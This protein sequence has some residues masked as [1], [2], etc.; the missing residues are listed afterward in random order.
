MLNRLPEIIEP[1]HLADKRGS[2]KGQLPINGLKRLCELLYSDEG[3]VTVD[4]FFNRE[5]RLAIV[6]GTIQAELQ[7]KC[8]NCLEALAWSVNHTVNLAIVNSIDQVNRLSE[9]YDPLLLEQG[10]MLL[11]DLVEDE[12]LLSLPIYP[13][14][15]H[16]C[17]VATDNHKTNLSEE[18]SASTNPF[19]I[20][21]TLKNIGD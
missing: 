2:L 3:L 19:S 1:L 7:L 20:L 5:G 14:H 17:F 13:K 9:D 11:K 10:T 6:A 21:A 18:K 15:Q 4:L 12:I 8:Q 16:S